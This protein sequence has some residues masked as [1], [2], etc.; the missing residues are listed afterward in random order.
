MA[1]N[2]TYGASVGPEPGMTYVG[3][4]AIRAGVTAMFAH[5]A[6]SEMSTDHPVMLGE[7]ALLTWTYRS[8]TPTATVRAVRGCDIFV[9]EG[10]QIRLKDA[11][12]K[13]E[14]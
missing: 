9:F 3:R 8:Q 4:T 1:P 12:R 6:D 14:V 13:T 10:G 2:A 11:Y 7:I 5:D